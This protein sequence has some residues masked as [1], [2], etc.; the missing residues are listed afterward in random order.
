MY[1][2]SYDM[3]RPKVPFSMWDFNEYMD[4]RKRKGL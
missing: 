2:C 3:D 4:V 1:V